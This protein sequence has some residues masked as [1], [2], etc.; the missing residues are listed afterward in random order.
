[1]IAPDEVAEPERS[2]NRLLFAVQDMGECR[3]A[4]DFLQERYD[5]PGDVRRA[6]ET[7]ALSAYA[8]PWGKSITI[9]AL[10]DHWLPRD[11]KQRGLHDALIQDRN[12]LYAHTDDEVG[13]RWGNW[14]T[15]GRQCIEEADNNPSFA[16]RGPGR[17]FPNKPLELSRL[18]LAGRFSW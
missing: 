8:R 10:G 17:T 5:I 4:A 7:G 6:L 9:G 18:R 15:V 12:K 13:A 14:R 11:P 16:V 3:A 1:M 2:F